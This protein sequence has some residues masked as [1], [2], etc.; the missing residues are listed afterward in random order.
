MASKPATL[1]PYSPQALPLLPMGEGAYT[2][3]ELDGIKRTLDS[4]LLM[5][6][7]PANKA[8][9]KLADGMIRYARTPFWPVAG[10]VAD[11]WVW[12]DLPNAVW[13]FL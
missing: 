13:K 4:I 11:A 3:R 1:I 10:Q 7:Q 2:Q 8:P 9:L 5:I 6:P 12:Y